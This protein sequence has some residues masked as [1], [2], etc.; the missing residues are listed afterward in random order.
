MG[1]II[2]ISIDGNGIG[3]R[4]E[5]LI[6]A[7]RFN[8]LRQFSSAVS[9]TVCEFTNWILDHNGN[10]IMSGGDNLLATLPHSLVS[11]LYAHVAKANPFDIRFAI[12]YGDKACDAYLALKYAKSNNLSL[13]R[14][15][16][17]HGFMKQDLMRTT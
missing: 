13:V 16:S 3:K 14:Y 9:M 5:A 10:V 1:N 15:N 8:E 6:L 7:N 17:E 2:F 4:I 12:G 11:Q